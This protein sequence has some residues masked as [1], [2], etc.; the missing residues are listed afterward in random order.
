MLETVVEEIERAKTNLGLTDALFHLLPENE[1]K[2][3]V[4]A[5]QIHFVNSENRRWWWEDFKFPSV[6]SH[7]TDGRGF[8]QLA[9]IVPDP[10]E[11]V[12]FIAEEDSLASYPLYEADTLTIQLVIGECYAF[13]Y[14]VVDK[15]FRWLVCENHH[16]VILGIGDEV[17]KRIQQ[18]H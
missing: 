18:L 5:V 2:Q 16:N 10:T 4:Q 14:Y 17:K 6:T 13:E 8:Q 9:L 7:F 15:D 1:A 3:I 11:K 12:W